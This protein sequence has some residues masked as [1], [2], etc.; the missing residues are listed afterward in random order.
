M[1]ARPS[2]RPRPRVVCLLAL[3]IA[4]LLGTGSGVTAA[5]ASSAPTA[6]VEVG[7]ATVERTPTGL[8]ISWA[9]SGNGRVRAIRWGIDPRHIDEPLVASVPKG[10]DSVTVDDPSPGARPYFAL[11]GDGG[12]RTVVAERRIA[13]EGSPNFRDLGGYET[14]DGRRVRWGQIYRS[15]ALDELT[16]TD[17]ATLESLGVK[18]VCDLRSPTEVEAAPD[19]ALPG[20]AA[21]SIPVFDKSV[22]PQAVREAVLAGDVS[23]LGAPGELL[24]EGSR[25]FITDFS[26][27]FE[28]MM[29]RLMDRKYRP[30]L[31]H[32][33]GGKDRA[34]LASAIV[35]LTLGVPEK[36]VMEDYLLSN[37]YRAEENAG[38]ITQLQAL[39]DPQELEV[40]RA[41][42]EVRPEYLQTSIDTMKD[43]YGSVDR[44]LRKGLGIS[45]AE[46]KRF[47][48]QMLESPR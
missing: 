42:I 46:R 30:A 8:V 21:L 18:L 2:T 32:C 44:Y 11:V 34:G 25:A 27:E 38:A 5:A 16:D 31:V 37:T 29:S 19:R 33:S 20:A 3:G 17:L 1:R 40:V 6:R 47:Q 41:L 45:K 39:L 23:T 35:L 43:E 28:Q 26:P 22:D 10:S 15:G 4:G 7:D 24:L 48:D 36:T 13:L 12:S 14:T 9:T